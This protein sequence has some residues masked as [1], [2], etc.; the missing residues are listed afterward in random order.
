[1]GSHGHTWGQDGTRT[2]PKELNRILVHKDLLHSLLGMFDGANC[3]TSSY[4]KKPQGVVARKRIS[5]RTGF[6]RIVPGTTPLIRE[7]K[8]CRTLNHGMKPKGSGAGEHF[9]WMKAVAHRT[10]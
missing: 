8:Q 9:H 6:R 2:Y 4:T 1:M 10:V 5:R 3:R 7:D